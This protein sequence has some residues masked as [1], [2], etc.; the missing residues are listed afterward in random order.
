MKQLPEGFDRHHIW[1]ERAG[2]TSRLEKKLR[3]HRGFI[4]P[5]PIDLHVELHELVLPPPKPE[6][7]RIHGLLAVIGD[8]ISPL[9]DAIEFFEKHG[10]IAIA[11]NLTKQQEI[12]YGIERWIPREV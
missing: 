1:F 5:M 8:S 6:P 10:D 7:E 3:G 9:A 4:V 2:Y 12:C 11:D